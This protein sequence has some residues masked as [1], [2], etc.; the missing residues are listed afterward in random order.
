M[1]GRRWGSESKGGSKSG[2]ESGS[3][4]RRKSESKG[5]SKSGSMSGSKGGSK[6]GS[7]SGSKGGS[8]GEVEGEDEKGEEVVKENFSTKTAGTLGHSI[9]GVIVSTEAEEEVGGEGGEGGEGGGGEEEGEE[10]RGEKRRESK[11]TKT[12]AGTIPTQANFKQKYKSPSTIS[13]IELSLD[14]TRSPA[15]IRLG[16]GLLRLS[17]TPPKEVSF[18]TFMAPVFH[19]RANSTTTTT[20]ATSPTVNRTKDSNN[21]SGTG[22]GAV[23]AVREGGNETNR[24]ESENQ[25]SIEVLMML[26]RRFGMKSY[27]A[28]KAI[29]ETDKVLDIHAR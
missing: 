24:A 16:I 29:D 20:N 25:I 2:S 11:K 10:E 21:T 3:E 15:P 13:T 1:S 22:G 14:V 9:R 12:L 6:G 8:K 23:T 19:W 17:K 5:G 28:Y 27:S 18:P 7:K 26:E 4:G